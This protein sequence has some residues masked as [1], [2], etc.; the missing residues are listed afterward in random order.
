MKQNI[1]KLANRI[2]H[3]FNLA[4]ASFNYVNSL[5]T[6]CSWNENFFQSIIFTHTFHL[7]LTLGTEK[8]YQQSFVKMAIR[9]KKVILLFFFGFLQFGANFLQTFV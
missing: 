1:Q 8:R 9:F 6:L 4:G 7:V 3:N 2:A 5:K